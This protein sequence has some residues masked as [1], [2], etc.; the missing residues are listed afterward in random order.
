VNAI[1]LVDVIKTLFLLC[2]NIGYSDFY[3]VPTSRHF[4][5]LLASGEPLPLRYLSRILILMTVIAAP[6]FAAGEYRQLDWMDLLTTADRTAMEHLPDIDHDAS[7][8]RK[9]D[10]NQANQAAQFTRDIRNEKARKQWQEVLN[11]TTVRPELDGIKVRIA[12]FLVPLETIA[13]GKVSEF[14]LVPYQGACVHVPP[15]PPNQLIYVKYAKGFA[16]DEQD[17]YEGFWVEGTLHTE[18]MHNKIASAAY[19]LTGDS[20]HIYK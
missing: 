6:A 7:P 1:L 8:E 14:F 11:A 19:T 17:F 10:P 18:L 15:P 16:F 12:G 13:P 2:Y 4:V 5:H 3:V 9:P 20:I